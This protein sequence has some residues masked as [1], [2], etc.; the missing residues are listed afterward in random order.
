MPTRKNSKRHDASRPGPVTPLAGPG[1]DLPP[2]R[3]GH[4]LG[5][6]GFMALCALA[7]I[8]HPAFAEALWRKASGPAALTNEPDQ[9]PQ[10]PTITKEMV[11]GA[12]ALIGL[13]FTDP[14]VDELVKTLGATMA[15][16]RTLR[17]VTV[18]NAVQPAL[19]FDPELPGRATGAGP[20]IR[21][22]E[23]R[24]K[25][26]GLTK[27]SDPAALAF[28][29]VA[30]L[31]ELVQTKQ[32]SAMELTRLYLDRIKRHD[33]VLQSVVTLT[34]ER[35]LNQARKAD[36]E[37]AAGKYKG[38]LHGIPWG[39]K[40]LFAVP[41]YPTTWGTGPFRDQRLDE[42]ATVVERLDR[43]GAVL[44][45]KLTLGELAMGDVW[46]GGTTKNPWKTDQGSSGSSAG[47]GS[48]TAAGLVGFSIGTE[49]LGSIVSP[50]TRNGV[51]GLRPTFGRV[52][53]HG[54]MALSWS[55]DKAGPMCRSVEDCGL[56]LR[57]IHG[58]DGRDQSA[59]DRPFGWSPGKGIAGIRVGYLKAAFDAEHDTKAFDDRALAELRSLGISLIPVEIP[60]DL[61]VAATRIILQAES[62]AAFDALT[63]SNQ[64]D[65]MT[66]Q[67][68]GTWPSNFRSARFI[69]AVEYINANRVRTLLMRQMDELMRRVDVFVTPSFGGQVLL[70]TNLTGHPSLTLPNGFRD[71]GT[72]VSLSFIGQLWG[73]ANLLAV[74]KA[75]QEATG[76]HRRHPAF[77]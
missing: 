77:G 73:E 31:A 39:A 55:M 60:L 76:F 12:A 4:R 38:P 70:V 9:E 53:R 14:E 34:E 33:A 8:S 10:T 17:G 13:E 51:T 21:L 11:V 43:A 47:P 71:D 27:P 24:P 56:V 23:G 35:A 5:R 42:T 57:A 2:S 45:A 30:E 49:T 65:Q 26:Q 54:A 67:G 32:V 40:D 74:G 6:R 50:S 1:A 58:A 28:L 7:G 61:P 69:P 25:R 59:V 62:A 16:V 37:I 41:G 64:D 29:T 36:D 22:G 44:V 63:R 46:Y 75:Y 48:A 3:D 52:S 15:S 19:R 72:P 20:R 68:A 18:P 66:R